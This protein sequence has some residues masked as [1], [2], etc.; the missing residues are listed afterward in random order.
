[1]HEHIMTQ[2][3]QRYEYDSDCFNCLP[4]TSPEALDALQHLLHVR[5]ER[6]GAC[7]VLV[8][9]AVA[10]EQLDVGAQLDHLHFRQRRGAVDAQAQCLSL[11]LTRRE[12]LSGFTASRV[13][14]NHE[15]DFA[16]HQ[17]ATTTQAYM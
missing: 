5:L 9:F 6:F 7:Q 4:L 14:S 17:P 8:D 15:F 11:L 2:R 10:D 13:Q 16:I 12:H 3:Y 1:M